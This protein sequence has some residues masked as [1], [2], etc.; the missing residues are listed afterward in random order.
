MLR[1]A[2][3]SRLHMLARGRSIATVQTELANRATGA[4]RLL[5][6]KVSNEEPVLLYL[7]SDEDVEGMTKQIRQQYSQPKSIRVV[8]PEGEIWARSTKLRD[9]SHVR[10][11]INIDDTKLLVLP[12]KEISW[13]I[14]TREAAEDGSF[15][16]RSKDVDATMDP[17]QVKSLLRDIVAIT[18]PEKRH[19][20]EQQRQAELANVISSCLAL[21]AP[22]WRMHTL[23]TLHT[24]TAFRAALC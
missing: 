10:Y 6:P 15:D 7:H 2:S 5:L 12:P 20:A 22:R 14:A 4:I 16:L 23:H 19:A 1:F 11:Q 17:E 13:N 8:T 24:R 18:D 21:C 9:L 3:L